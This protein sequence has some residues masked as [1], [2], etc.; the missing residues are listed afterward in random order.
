MVKKGLKKIMLVILFMHSFAFGA[1]VKITP[2]NG[3]ILDGKPFFPVAVY[4]QPI[5][6]FDMLNGLGIDTF[7]VEELFGKET[8]KTYLDELNKRNS[9]GVIKSSSYTN[10]LKNH[11]ALLGW[12]QPDEPDIAGGKP[13]KVPRIPPEKIIADYKDMKNKDAFH[14]VYLNFGS[15]QAVGKP[16]SPVKMYYEFAK[17]ADIV[18]FDLYPVNKYGDDML[19]IV[20]KGMDR[21]RKYVDDKKPGWIWLECSY[22]GDKGDL[23]APNASQL[24]TEVWMSIVHGAKAI[25]YF[26]HT[27]VPKYKCCEIPNDV[28][29]EM[30]RTNAKIKAMTNILLA[31]D[32]KREVKCETEGESRVDILVKE[33]EE[34]IYIFAVN[35][36]KKADK[37]KFVI[38]GIKETSVIVQDENRK[39]EIKAGEFKDSFK[40]Y[41]VHIYEINAK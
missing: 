19:H 31:P 10:E 17:G 6:M 29:A 28:Q 35:M 3:M 11:P 33:F 32:S 23:K 9:Y 27:W 20:A 15:G 13:I 34:K 36:K 22:I 25:G 1:N 21:L 37:A 40:E 5:K 30:K 16:P 39:K 7:V 8:P 18:A 41:E 26:P 2:E 38:S 24:K 14:P 12:A 4:N